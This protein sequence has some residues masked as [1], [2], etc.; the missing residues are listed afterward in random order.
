MSSVFSWITKAVL[1]TAILVAAITISILAFLFF[2]FF[3]YSPFHFSGEGAHNI[4]E[5]GLAYWTADGRYLFTME[6]QYG[7]GRL[8]RYDT[9][10]W[11]RYFY[12]NIKFGGL[13]SVSP[14]GRMILSNYEYENS[15]YS[16]DLK[17]YRKSVLWQARGKL[18]LYDMHWIRPDIILMIG[19][20]PTGL[21]DV[22]KL[23]VP[24]GRLTKLTS[25]Y[26]GMFFPAIDGSGFI[27]ENRWDNKL[28]FQELDT[29]KERAIITRHLKYFRSYCYMYLSKDVLIYQKNTGPEHQAE[30][31]DLATLKDTHFNLDKPG[32]YPSA[33]VMSPN[34]TMYLPNAGS[35]HFGGD[36]YVYDLPKA[37]V[38]IIKQKIK[39]TSG[40]K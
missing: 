11:K 14:N 8:Y 3:D 6:G 25:N 21:D 5:A 26:G 38:K 35:S 20:T 27:Y 36:R 30:I 2:M 31:L 7:E 9:K 4:R 24:D 18:D 12:K 39:E 17:T 19:R 1:I 33:G 29:G 13:L 15:L 28:H 32:E 16:I 34:L 37:A 23:S 40:D 22:Y 10:T